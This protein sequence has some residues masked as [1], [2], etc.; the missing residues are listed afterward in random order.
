MQEREHSCKCLQCVLNSAQPQ[1]RAA[2]SEN[3]FSVLC[4]RPKLPGHQV[5]VNA[6]GL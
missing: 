3:P 5:D 6:E 4:C 1:V 2:A